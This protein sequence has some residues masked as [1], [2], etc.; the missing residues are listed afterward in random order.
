MSAAVLMC[1]WI[2]SFSPGFLT[3]NFYCYLVDHLIVLHTALSRLTLLLCPA[4]S[5]PFTLLGIF[6]VA[7]SLANLQL[8]AYLNFNHELNFVQFLF[9]GIFYSFLRV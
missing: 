8:S 2:D 6:L 1:Q 7:D 4:S 5:L 9:I 3:H